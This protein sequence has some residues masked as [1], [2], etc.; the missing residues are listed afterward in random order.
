MDNIKYELYDEM[1]KLRVPKVKT[2]EETIDVMINEHCSICRFGDGELSLMSGQSIPMQRFSVALQKRLIEVFSSNKVHIKIA[3][4]KSCYSS[5]ANLT[6]INK[7]FWRSTGPRFRQ[8]MAQY[9]N[10]DHQYYAAEVTL[11]YSYFKDYDYQLYF[12]NMRK[13]WH[14]KD[15]V[16]ICGQTVFDKIKN[17]IFDNARNIEY[18]YTPSIDA[19]NQ[20][21]DILEKALQIDKSKMCILICGPTA[22][23]L[24]YDLGCNNYKAL[25]LGHI[26][27]SY[28][29]FLQNRRTDEM[30]DA[31]DFFNPD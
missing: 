10:Y 9:L 21:E 27:K 5:K 31:V 8:L 11:A 12:D 25:D 18:L 29:W 30:A 17:N 7:D 23:V 24:A 2:V 26:A 19:F 22:K 6:D 15:I 1:T 4:L 28:D 16:L 3:I 20:Y 13:I 14:E